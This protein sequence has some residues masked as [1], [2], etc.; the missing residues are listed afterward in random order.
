MGRS[1]A[2]LRPKTEFNLKLLLALVQDQA[3]NGR[4]YPNHPY[5]L[6]HILNIS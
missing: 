4:K 1:T 5:V 6:T 2:V 3:L